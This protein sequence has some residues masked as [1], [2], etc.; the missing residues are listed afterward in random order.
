[1]A[2]KKHSPYAGRRL[3]MYTLWLTV[4]F[5]IA[6]VTGLRQYTNILSGTASYGTVEVYFGIMYIL[7]YLCFVILVPIFLI[8]FTCMKVLSFSQKHK[9]LI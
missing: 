4:L 5:I 9:K 8:A 2:K 1:M 6:H 7:L 3:I